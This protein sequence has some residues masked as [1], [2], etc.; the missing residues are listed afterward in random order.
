MFDATLRLE[1]AALSPRSLMPLVAAT[2]RVLDLIYGHAA[3]LW[4]RG[5][6]VRRHP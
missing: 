3:V 2:L 6:V 1:R 5:V 4:L